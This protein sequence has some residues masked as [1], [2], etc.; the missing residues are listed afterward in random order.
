MISTEG[1][2]PPAGADFSLVAG[3]TREQR[4]ARKEQ[5]AADRRERTLQLQQNM[6]NLR[7]RLDAAAVA[8]AAAHF[9]A[10][11]RFGQ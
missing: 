3:E 5:A 4:R 7:Q 11:R 2:C 8:L 9:A 1:A 6:V 10:R